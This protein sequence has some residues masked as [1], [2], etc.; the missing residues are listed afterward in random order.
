MSFGNTATPPQPIGSPQP[1]KV[2][3]ATEGGAAKPSHQTGRPVP[4]TPSRSRTTPSVINAVTPR[5]T[6]R[7]HKISPKMPASVI[8]M[9]STTA[10]QPVGMA[11]IAVRVEIGDDQDS[12]V[13][14]SSRA[15]TKRRVKAGPTSRF[16]PGRSGREPRN[17]TFRRPFLSRTVVMVAVVTFERVVIAS[18]VRDIGKANSGK[19]EKRSRILRSTHMA[20]SAGRYRY[21]RDKHDILS[22]KRGPAA[23]DEVARG[24]T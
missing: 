6:M 9:A 24:P 5:L 3:P 16:C 21:P 19:G 14:R 18:G 4:S 7:A 10:I 15:G 20:S 17:Q 2:R 1:T 22:E 8:A 23:S 13:A 12:G 11:S